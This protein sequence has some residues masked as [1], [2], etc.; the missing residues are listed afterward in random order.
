[1]DAWKQAWVAPPR[2]PTK[3]STTKPTVPKDEG[4]SPVIPP[5]ATTA[6]PKAGPPVA[7]SPGSRRGILAVFDIDDRGLLQAPQRD[8]LTEILATSLSAAG[9]RVVPRSQLRER[10]S[11]EKGK[12]YGACIDEACQ[13]ELGKAMAAE[14]SLATQIISIEGECTVMATLF[15]LRTETADGS[16]VVDRVECTSL[17]MKR[18]LIG[19][20]QQLP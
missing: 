14:K 6:A 12:S 5:R 13:I 7:R 9:F 2:K 15:D 11:A 4:N 3:P 10:I 18:A 16:I 20:A 8:S 1:M 17:A 19:L